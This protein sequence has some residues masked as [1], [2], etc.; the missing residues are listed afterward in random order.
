MKVEMTPECLTSHS[1]FFCIGA[2][3]HFDVMVGVKELQCPETPGSV[4]EQVRAS[5]KSALSSSGKA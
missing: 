1:F 5:P 3:C 2:L 4:S